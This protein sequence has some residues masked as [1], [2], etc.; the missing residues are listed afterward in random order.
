[1]RVMM[2]GL[3]ILT[4][5]SSLGLLQFGCQ[6]MQFG[7]RPAPSPAPATTPT[8]QQTHD[9]AEAQEALAR[10]DYTAAMQMFRAILAENPTISTAYIGVGAIYMAQDD[11]ARAEPAYARA[12]RLE[13]RNFDAQFGHG[14]ALQML[15]RLVDAMRAY[16]RALTIQPEHPQAN[17][18]LATTYLQMEDPQSALVFA[19]KAVQTDPANGAA[20]AN[21]G[22]IYEQL[23]RNAEAIDQYLIALELIDDNAPLMLNL[24]NALGKERRYREAVNTAAMLVR[25]SPSANAYERLGW[26]H[27]RLGEY[28][29]SIQA[30]RAAV[31]LDSQHWPSWSGIGVNALNQWLLSNREDTA[32]FNEARRAFR[33]SLLINRDQPRLVT[34]MSN[35]GL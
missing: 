18:N 3:L 9:L 19:E 29:E 15:N 2:R 26:G 25:V 28:E 8:A 17:L 13:P 33:R 5:L 16:H 7:R 6:G 14:L 30:Y 22:A 11:Y 10:G 23:D 20:R 34:V 12:A 24:I 35:Y 32:A 4:L 21:L 1:M 27:F 31:D